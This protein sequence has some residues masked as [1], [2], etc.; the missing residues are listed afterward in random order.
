[1]V[2]GETTLLGRSVTGLTDAEPLN[3]KPDSQV[4]VR[5]AVYNE[6]ERPARPFDVRITG[7]V[8]GMTFFEYGTRV[9]ATVAPDAVL[10]KSVVLELDDLAGKGVGRVPTTLSIVDEDGDVLLE[11][12]FSVDVDGS[13]RSAYG[14]FGLAVAA[15]TLVLLVSL[16][17]AIWRGLLPENRWRR[18]LRFLPVGSGL[19]LTLTF[20]LS[21]LSLL[22]PSG[23]WWATFVLAF[24]AGAFLL[25]YFLPMPYTGTGTG[26]QAEAD[27]FAA[28][29]SAPESPPSPA[30]D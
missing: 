14:I 22:T 5:L 28:R 7:S 19:G 10:T 12:S 26:A 23:T 25:G 6:G 29:D 2:W 8:M 1:M 30:R 18:A 11:Q 24:S 16:L 13:L 20:T 21:A 17:L 3:L 27:S 4:R 15:S 9:D